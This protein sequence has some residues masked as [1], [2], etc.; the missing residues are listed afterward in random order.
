MGNACDGRRPS[1]LEA[2]VPGL[3]HAHVG[4]FVLLAVGTREPLRE[5]VAVRECLLGVRVGVVP[6]L[7]RV[8]VGVPVVER[9]LLAVCAAD[10]ESER[11]TNPAP[12]QG[13][14]VTVDVTVVVVSSV[15]VVVTVDVT[16]VV[17]VV[18]VSMVTVTV[19]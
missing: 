11:Q 13:V 17:I 5:G 9:V 19:T 16:V 2:P 1:S 12:A 18:V 8:Q 10:L 6:L 15:A 7:A 14:E 4:R 3:L